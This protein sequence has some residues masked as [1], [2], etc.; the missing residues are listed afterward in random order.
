MK[1]V[2]G[3][4]V[5]K[6][7]FAHQWVEDLLYF[8]GPLL[9]LLKASTS[10]DYF[11]FHIDQDKAN[12]RWLAFTVSRKDIRDYLSRKKTLLE[13]VY[14][15]ESVELVDLDFNGE[16]V[17][18]IRCQVSDMPPEYL[19][20]EDSWFI[21]ELAPVSDKDLLPA[22]SNYSLKVGGDWFFEDFA[23]LPVY[24]IQLYSFFYSL[25]NIDKPSVRSNAHE[26]YRRYPWRGGYSSV[27]FFRELKGVIPSLHEPEVVAINYASPGVIKLALLSDVAERLRDALIYAAKNEYELDHLSKDFRRVQRDQKWADVDGTIIKLRLSKDSRK[28]LR[29]TLTRACVLLGIPEYRDLIL[30]MAGNDLRA[31]KIMLAY[32]RRTKKLSGFKDRQLVHF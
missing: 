5:R 23:R 19:P 26:I 17:E 12:V 18:A 2:I 27:N 30:K 20:G 11:Y 32:Y 31:V 8:E 6:S 29:R 24:Y 15:R 16:V 7:A 22:P 25:V 14:E 21:S 28:F 1:N 9:S 3:Q 13:M 4:R 10:Q